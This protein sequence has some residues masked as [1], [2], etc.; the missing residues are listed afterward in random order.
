LCTYNGEKYIGELLYSLINQTVQP[1]EIIICDDKS[2]DNTVSIIN[3]ILA[4]WDG[5][6]KVVKNEINLGYKKN[7]QKAIELCTGDIIFL[8][9]QDD[10]WNKEKIKYVQEAFQNNPNAVLVFHDAQLVNSELQEIEPSFW[11]ILHF[12]SKTFKSTQYQSLLYRNVVQG[13]AC[14]FRKNLFYLSRPFPSQAI[15]DEWL[16]LNAIKYGQLFPL[17]KCL[18][19]YRQT[20][21]NEIGALEGTS[22]V[23]IKK[24]LFSLKRALNQCVEDLERRKEVW[25]AL[26]D[27]YKDTLVI[28]TMTAKEI[29][30]F[31]GVRLY[32]IKNRDLIHALNFHAYLKIYGGPSFAVKNF[33]K[34]IILIVM[35]YTK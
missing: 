12:D 18:L 29:Y 30:A 26:A 13:A 15:H 1:D 35:G 17:N 31:S 6:W 32:R 9:D 8:C 19:K 33:L 34:D 5:K 22:K 21:N 3:G 23:K 4:K 2:K 27:K 25:K 10:V 20:G 24:W 7:F 16:A 28:G 11:N 14:A